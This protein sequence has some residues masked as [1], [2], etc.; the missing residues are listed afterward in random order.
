MAFRSDLGAALLCVLGAFQDERR[1]LMVE[2]RADVFEQAG[3]DL[4][5][6]YAELQTLN[7]WACR[8]AA[9]LEKIAGVPKTP[10]DFLETLQ[11]P[12]EEPGVYKTPLTAEQTDV[13]RFTKPGSSPNRALGMYEEGK[14]EGRR[15]MAREIRDGREPRV[16][17]D[18]GKDLYLVEGRWLR[19]QAE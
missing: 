4:R 16:G 3:K 11:P 6:V 7:G 8:I 14:A 9:A 15:E 17:Y 13:P 18:H 2:P 19:E 1:I 12:A 5:G 10:R